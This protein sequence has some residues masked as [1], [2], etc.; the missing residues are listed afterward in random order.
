LRRGANDVLHRASKTVA[1]II[2]EQNVKPVMEDLTNIRDRIRYGRKMNR[3]LHSMPF[4]KIQFYINYKA[5]EQ[6]F[7]PELVDAKNTSRTRPI[8][9]GLN[10][11][12][13]HVYEFRAC[14][15]QADKQLAA[16]WNI[17]AKHTMC[18]PS[19]LA[20][21]ALPEALKAEGGRIVIKY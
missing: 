18:R 9:G 20:V 3:R 4:R 8:C 14:G 2:A 17:A 1:R 10:K 19:P 16:V 21:K 11:P 13:G 12:N 5:M 7:K 6:G 15:L